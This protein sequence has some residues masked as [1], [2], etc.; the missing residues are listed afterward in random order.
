MVPFLTALIPALA[1]VGAAGASAYASKQQAD[2]YEEGAEESNQMNLQIAREQMQFQERMRSTAHQT[3]VEDLRKAGL[4]PIL[5]SGGSGAAV[6]AGSSAVMQNTQLGK[7]QAWADAVQKIATVI[8]TQAL[9][10][11]EKTKQAQNLSQASLAEAETKLTTAKAMNELENTRFI[12]A[13]AAMKGQEAGIATSPLG[14]TKA[15]LKYLL[16]GIWPFGSSQSPK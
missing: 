8:N 11:T 13:Q 1:T 3:E 6:P 12:R 9:T 10:D 5:S 7:A 15:I 4:N 14:R 2:A 16:E